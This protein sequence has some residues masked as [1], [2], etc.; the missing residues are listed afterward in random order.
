ML[1]DNRKVSCEGA[2]GSIHEAEIG[3]HCSVPGIKEQRDVSDWC[4]S[5]GIP[6]VHTEWN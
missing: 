2:N 5:Y 4:I 6:R 3:E 1:F